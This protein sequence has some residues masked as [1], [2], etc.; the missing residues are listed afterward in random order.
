MSFPNVRLAIH[1]GAG[2]ISR[3]GLTP[4]KETAYRTALDLALQAGTNILSNGGTAL[5]AVAV[6]VTSLE[7]CPLFN[8]GRGSV[9][10]HEGR[11]EM[12]AAIMDGRNRQAGAVAGVKLVR[13]PILL[14]RAVME[15][16]PHV[17]LCGEGAEIFGRSV[18][19]EFAPE[20][21]FYDAFR[22]EQWKKAVAEERIQ[23]DHTD[24]RKFGTVGAVALDLYG[25]LAAA[26]STGGMTNKKWGRIGD[27]PVIGAGTWADNGSV[28]ISCT[29]SGE[30]FLRAVVAH[31]IACLMS[32]R[33]L[34]LTESCKIVVHEKL[35]KLGGDGGLIAVDCLG[36]LCL[37]FNTPGMYRAWLT[38]DGTRHTAIFT[39]E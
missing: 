12:D 10:N 23:L 18:G 1:G 22:F 31:D 14:A 15:K 35:P 8:A 37:P 24:E 11:Q 21:Y 4:E 32:Y 2:T 16:S 6:A 28:A 39:E 26:T 13:N 34:S 33:G 7:D 27:S 9:F 30:Y 17:L 20:E 29:G 19:I 25:N 38:P 3:T 5:D 36:N